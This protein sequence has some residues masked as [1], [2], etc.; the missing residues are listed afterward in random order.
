MATAARIVK[1]FGLIFANGERWWQLRWFS[2]TALRNFGTGKRIQEERI[3]EEVWC[4]VEELGNTK[5]HHHH[6][7]AE[8]SPPGY[9][10]V[11]KPKRL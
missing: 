10:S 3:Q 7:L 5:G 6:P 4:L 9:K 2:L 1:V 8:L 11:Q